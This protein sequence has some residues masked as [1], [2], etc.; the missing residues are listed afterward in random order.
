[1]FTVKKQLLIKCTCPRKITIYAREHRHL[2]EIL[3]IVF[4]N[5]PHR[6]SKLIGSSFE[7]SLLFCR[8]LLR[9]GSLNCCRATFVIKNLTSVISVQS[10]WNTFFSSSLVFSKTAGSVLSL[11][12]QNGLVTRFT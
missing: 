8:L 10:R 4:V 3:K 2:K 5:E 7:S 1:M 9:K 6:G 11:L 12:Q